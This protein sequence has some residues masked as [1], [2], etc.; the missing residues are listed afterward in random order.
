MSH[1][2]A[3]ELD[4]QTFQIRVCEDCGAVAQMN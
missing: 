4:L 2:P 3:F 1:G